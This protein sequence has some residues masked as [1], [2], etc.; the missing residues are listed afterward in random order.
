MHVCVQCMRS[1]QASR[2]SPPAQAYLQLHLDH[3]CTM[4]APYAHHTH[5]MHIPCTMYQAY[6]QYLPQLQLDGDLFVFEPEPEPEPE[7]LTKT[8][9]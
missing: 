2:L 6:L 7:P 1:V 4:H 8:E 9:P 3:A 5:N